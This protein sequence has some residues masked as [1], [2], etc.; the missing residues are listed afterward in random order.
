MPQQSRFLLLREH[1][2]EEL[3]RPLNIASGKGTYH[4]ARMERRGAGVSAG[5]CPLRPSRPR[6]PNPSCLVR[7]RWCDCLWRPPCT[8][9]P[10]A[11]PRGGG[12]G[13]LSLNPWT[14]MPTGIYPPQLHYWTMGSGEWVSGCPLP[15]LL[16]TTI[17][18]NVSACKPRPLVC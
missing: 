6:S 18:Q 8:T 4:P 7:R 16:K 2:Q 14:C 11:S 17:A 5:G 12:L 10:F 9:I 3:L 15:C 1:S 13:V